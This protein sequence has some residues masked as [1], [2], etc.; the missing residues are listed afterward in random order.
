MRRLRLPRSNNL[1]VCDSRLAPCAVRLLP[2][3][4]SSMMKYIISFLVVVSSFYCS[5]QIHTEKELDC[6]S[7][8]R[9]SRKPCEQFNGMVRAVN[10]AKVEQVDCSSLSDVRVHKSCETFNRMARAHDFTITTQLG[11]EHF[12]TREYQGK[13]LLRYET[14]YVCFKPDDA[15]FFLGFP[16]LRD[17]WA[18]LPDGK[19]R[20]IGH[21]SYRAYVSEVGDEDLNVEFEWTRQCNAAP[22]S[23]DEPQGLSTV[24]PGPIF[25]ISPKEVKLTK[26]NYRRTNDTSLR[27]KKTANSI[28]VVKILRSTLE[29]TVATGLDPI[30]HSASSSLTHGQCHMFIS[31]P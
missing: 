8:P 17:E 24:F 3:R 9:S 27:A 18:N 31:N 14:T 28:S 26:P 19:Q 29:S 7:R 4:G 6:S 10:T 25:S 20:Q 11:S 22:S 30:F 15:F 21:V 2:E 16:T 23:C 5:A 1:D 13:T 12:G